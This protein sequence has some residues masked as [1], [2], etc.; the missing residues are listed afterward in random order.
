LRTIVEGVGTAEVWDLVHAAG[1]DMAQGYF[2]GRP[3]P[4]DDLVETLRQAGR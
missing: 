2:F 4:F 1:A 3:A